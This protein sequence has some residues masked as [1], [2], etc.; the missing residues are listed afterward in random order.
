MLKILL[1][2]Q[3]GEIFRSW[4]YNEKKGKSRSVAST[5]M[6]IILFVL[7]V[8][9]LVGGMFSIVAIALCKP[10]FAADMG[11]LYFTILGLIAIFLGVF[12]SV[13]NTFSAL[14][15]S[16]DNDL[17]LS[18]PIPV[19]SIIASRLLSVYLMGLMY[20]SIVM[21]P[22][23]IVYWI[24]AP[25]GISGFFGSLILE[26]IISV[27]I[28]VLSC[29]LGW[30][31][32]KIS[33]KLKNKSF[34]T[35]FISLVFFAAYYFVYY[36]A[37]NIIMS[38]SANAA[39]YGEKIKGSAYPLFLFGCVGTGNITAMLIFLFASVLVFVLTF[40][41]LSKNF[42]HIATSSSDTVAVKK[43]YRKNAVRVKS[44]FG[45]LLGKE[46]HRLTSSANYMLNCAL[47]TLIIPVCGV[48]LLIKGKLLIDVLDSQLGSG[49]IFVIASAVLSIL[50][51]MNITAAPSVS[52]EGKSIWILQSLPV[53][54]MQI[55]KAK[56][57]VHLILTGI[58][59][60][61]SII[62]IA[63]VLPFDAIN[64]V[65]LALSVMAYV[66]FSGLFDLYIG[67]KTANVN[68]TNEMTPIKQSSAS[69]IAIFGS[70]GYCIAIAAIYFAVGHT[71][72]TT[73]YLLIFTLL[74][75]LLSAILYRWIRK[76]GVTVFSAL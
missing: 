60:I 30:V 52:L 1:K 14:Y 17:L 13:F 65:F 76:R 61:F 44:T 35:V 5:L 26:L 73:L 48:L 32:A 69:L 37:Q 21:L 18:M 64:F 15:L 57:F 74:P 12:G 28:L 27:L 71:I 41:I 22:A 20:S 51:S 56:L 23:I 59:E 45:A 40:K 54:T 4:F 53:N 2:K 62:C 42:I 6:L 66:L 25:C 68:W 46:F 19:R 55:L 47:G 24:T 3:L 8:F 50:S 39:I 33:L 29:I 11:W 31:V 38:I 16:K 72:G 34:I 63:F 70:W 9:G 36:K 10:L 75:L 7:L 58:P 43:S 49:A 67:L